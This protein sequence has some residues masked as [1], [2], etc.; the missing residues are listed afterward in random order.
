MARD[1]KAIPRLPRT[2]KL[3]DSIMWRCRP[4]PTKR[5]RPVPGN[6]WEP[7]GD[8]GEAAVF[9]QALMVPLLIQGIRE[10]GLMGPARMPQAGLWGDMGDSHFKTVYRRGIGVPDDPNE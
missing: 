7:G 9:K 1:L 6:R 4:V 8:G 2:S 5:W 10:P 3:P